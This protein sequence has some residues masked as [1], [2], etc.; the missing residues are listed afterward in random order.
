MR[1][2]PRASHEEWRGTEVRQ[3]VMRIIYEVGVLR[4]SP[5]IRC[6]NVQCRVPIA[7]IGNTRVRHEGRKVALKPPF[8]CAPNFETHKKLSLHIAKFEPTTHLPVLD[9]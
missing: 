8:G 9:L 6:H 3:Y 5:G 1:F 7:L 2:V 4:T